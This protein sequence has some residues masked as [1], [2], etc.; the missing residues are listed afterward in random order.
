MRIF[1]TD[2]EGPITVNDNAYEL[3]CHYLPNGSLFYQILSKYDD[4]LADVIKRP[5]YKSGDTLKLIAPF[6][7]AYGVTNET[8]VDF[9]RKTL[10]FVPGAIEA[11]RHINQIMPCYI[12][13]TS[14]E[15]YIRVV[16][17][18]AGVPLANAYCTKIDLNAFKL[19]VH[20]IEQLKELYNRVIQLEYS[21]ISKAIDSA[22]KK[23]DEIFWV[24]MRSMKAYSL[25]ESINPVG[26]Y[27][28]C[29]AVKLIASAS[30]VEL[31]NLIYV[32]DSITDSSALEC[33]KNSNGLAVAFNGN[34]Y[35]IRNAEI[36]I[37]SNTALVLAGI[38]E[39]FAKAGK[40]KIIDLASNWDFK[41]FK[42]SLSQ[43]LRKLMDKISETPK[44]ELIAENNRRQLERESQLM[45]E[46]VRGIAVAKLG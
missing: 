5:N 31:S 3:T 14:Y 46:K 6:L 8:I 13:S 12:V 45:R 4:I 41:E 38:A 16:C 40:E 28:K 25:M 33:I 23:L 36:A 7:K 43:Q 11:L 39:L 15:H 24:K 44:V 32:G 34:K 35:A 17:E 20:E 19:P 30:Q 27:E 26:G 21:D 29:N 9:S 18:K 22:I 37:I 42:R 10:A 2:C 1:I